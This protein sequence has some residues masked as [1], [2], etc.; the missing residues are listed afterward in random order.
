MIYIIWIL[1][2]KHFGFIII[3]FFLYFYILFLRWAEYTFN[4]ETISRN[5]QADKTIFAIRF[6]YID[7]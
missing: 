6:T 1:K 7:L 4:V 3:W 5:A 2:G